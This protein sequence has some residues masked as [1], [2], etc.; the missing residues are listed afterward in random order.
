MKHFKFELRFTN[1]YIEDNVEDGFRSG[2]IFQVPVQSF[3]FQFLP[4]FF[5]GGNVSIVRS[6]FKARS[7]TRS[8]TVT[9]CNDSLVLNKRK[10]RVHITLRYVIGLL[11]P[12][13]D[14]RFFP[15]YL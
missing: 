6:Y 9:Q 1:A 4:S 8:E 12:H 15:I 5:S 2:C 14:R 3:A 11:S 7:K 13:N 10:E